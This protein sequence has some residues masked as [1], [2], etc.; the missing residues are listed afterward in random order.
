ME[1]L[2]NF[3]EVFIKSLQKKCVH[4][5]K[6]VEAVQKAVSFFCSVAQYAEIHCYARTQ[7]DLMYARFKSVFEIQYVREVFFPLCKM[8]CGNL[9]ELGVPF[10]GF[11]GSVLKMYFAIW[12]LVFIS[13]Y[14]DGGTC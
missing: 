5:F 1:T 8:K 6:G 10:V 7:G 4:V 3:S 12:F 11:V 9:G 2:N 14:K 13:G